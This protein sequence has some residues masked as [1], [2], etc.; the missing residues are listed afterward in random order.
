MCNSLSMNMGLVANSS[1]VNKLDRKIKLFVDARWLTQPGQGVYTY[2]CEVYKRLSCDY[3][4]DFEIY[5]GCVGDAVPDFLTSSDRVLTYKSDAL[6][7]R[8][9]MLGR[10]INRIGIDVAHFQYYLPRGLRSSVK[11]IVTIHDVIF[12]KEKRLFPLMYKVPRYFL[13]RDAAIRA[14]RVVTI[15]EQSRDDLAKYFKLSNMKVELIHLGMD[16]ALTEISPVP[17]SNQFLGSYLLTVGRHEP[18]KNYAR[19]VEAYARSGIHERMGIQLVIAG[20]YSRQF[21]N[22]LPSAPGVVLL[23]DCTNAQLAWLYRHARGFIFAS[24]AEGYGLPVAEALSFGIPVAISSTYPIPALQARAL[25]VFDPYSIPDMVEAIDALARAN[26]M[27][28]PVGRQAVWNWGD[29]ATA[30]RNTLIDLA[31]GRR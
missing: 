20:W 21:D 16:T 14:Q 31:A 2:L 1:R 24:I 27:A 12:M 15:S 30:H 25:S 8:Y 6:A 23:P 29:C 18:R 13:F 4:D 19:L 11:G 5:Y 10:E 9:L 26:S 7:W 17:V 3:A 28:A 22:E